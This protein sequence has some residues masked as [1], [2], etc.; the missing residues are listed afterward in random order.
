MPDEATDRLGGGMNRRM[1]GG[2]D[3][4]RNGQMNGR[5]NGWM[6]KLKHIMQDK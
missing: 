4:R 6:D 2:T 5:V 1:D 3:G